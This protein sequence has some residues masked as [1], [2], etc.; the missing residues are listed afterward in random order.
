MCLRAYAHGAHDGSVRA[1][2]LS[3]TTRWER[4]PCTAHGV[5]VCALAREIGAFDSLGAASERG[6]RDAALGINQSVS[7]IILAHHDSRINHDSTHRESACA[8][9]D[10]AGTGSADTMRDCES[11][12]DYRRKS[13]P[14]DV[15]CNTARLDTTHFTGRT[16][17][18][19][20]ARR[21]AATEDAEKKPCPKLRTMCCGRCH[22]TR[23]AGPGA[24]RD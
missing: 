10:P 9:T 2:G 11:C 24:G 20:H 8:A 5:G 22:A 21:A 12:D 6:G 16:H 3:R 17:W 1:C 4:W 15:V 23:A 7:Q 14:R 13:T 18:V 19:G